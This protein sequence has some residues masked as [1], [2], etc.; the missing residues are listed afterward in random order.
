MFITKTMERTRRV[1]SLL[2]ICESSET[3][4][5]CSLKSW[6]QVQVKLFEK[7]I[8]R[9]LRTGILLYSVM[10]YWKS[11]N[12]G[13]VWLSR[14]LFVVEGYIVVC[15]ENFL[16][17]GSLT[18]TASSYLSLDSCCPIHDILEMV[19]EPEDSKCVTL[20]MDHAISKKYCHPGKSEEKMCYKRRPH[21]TSH[22]S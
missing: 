10:L 13:D 21:M 14:S 15:I 3:S 11:S 12:E 8:C 22:G 16:E 4:S 5:K 17:F 19:I 9:T 6:E 7:H 2:Q 20:S 1:L 18:D